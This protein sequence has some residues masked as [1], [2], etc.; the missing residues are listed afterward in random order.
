MIYS[1]SDTYN[2]FQVS[3]DPD[4]TVM[5]KILKL[6][7]FFW[8]SQISPVFW[9]VLLQIH[10]G[11]G[12]NRIRIRN[13]VGSEWIRIHNTG[14]IERADY[15]KYPR[16]TRKT[17]S[18]SK[19]YY[20]IKSGIKI[21]HTVPVQFCCSAAKV[22]CGSAHTPPCGFHL[23][24]LLR[25][26]RVHLQEPELQECPPLFLSICKGSF[27]SQQFFSTKISILN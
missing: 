9:V 4:Q 16:C 14:S 24:R 20:V 15:V 10:F 3:P 7:I 23:G 12:A 25:A 8:D 19:V 13:D 11:S 17:S 5:V 22:C 18:I 2:T 27:L 6:S 1:R 26:Y 21:T